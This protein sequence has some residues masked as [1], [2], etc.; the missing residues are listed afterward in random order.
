MHAV[1]LVVDK[2]RLEE[3]EELPR[4]VF[5]AVRRG[6]N[7]DWG[8]RVIAPDIAQLADDEIAARQSAALLAA[9]ELGEQHCAH[10][11]AQ[12][13]QKAAQFVGLLAVDRHAGH[14]TKE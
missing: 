12:F 7:R 6:P 14:Q 8:R 11:W 5:V 2:E 13:P 1:G 10:L 9:F 4:R 3:S